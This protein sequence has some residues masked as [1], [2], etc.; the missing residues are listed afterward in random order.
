MSTAF[1]RISCGWVRMR[2]RAWA[3]ACHR[4]RSSCSSGT[5]GSCQSAFSSRSSN[6]TMTSP[7]QSWA[8]NVPSRALRLVSSGAV[9]DL[10]VAPGGVEAPAVERADDAGALDPPADADVGAEMRAVRLH[11]VDIAVVGAEGDQV[12]AE[13]AERWS[14]RRPGS[15]RRGRRGT[16]RSGSRGTGIDR[17]SLRALAVHGLCPGPAPPPLADRRSPDTLPNASEPLGPAPRGATPTRRGHTWPTCGSRRR[18]RVRASASSA[19][20][21]SRSPR[22]Q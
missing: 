14:A 3:G 2:Q 12:P 9:G 8:S 21:S 10:D 6:H 15:P 19:S 5:S 17:S 1:S 11:D 16:S 18:S 7:H 4:S 13:V 22:R 20:S